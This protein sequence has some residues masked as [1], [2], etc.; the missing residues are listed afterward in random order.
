MGRLYKA[1]FGWKDANTLREG[2]F[3][4]DVR[5]VRVVRTCFLS[6]YRWALRVL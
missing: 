5:F 1:F 3:L 2:V 4:K 6:G